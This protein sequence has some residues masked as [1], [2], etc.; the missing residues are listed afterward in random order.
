MLSE[1]QIKEYIANLQTIFDSPCDHENNLMEAM[2]CALRKMH[3]QETIR[4]M[5]DILDPPQGLIEAMKNT[6][7]TALEIKEQE[8]LD[9][10]LK[11]KKKKGKKHGESNPYIWG[12]KPSSN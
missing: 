7:E 11:A 9:R 3:I 1:Q 2:R 10:E 5:S 12:N 4:I 8:Q 6:E